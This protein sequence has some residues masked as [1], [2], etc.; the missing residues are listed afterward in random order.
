MFKNTINNKVYIGQSINI[1]KRHKE[2][3]HNHLNGNYCNYNS[4]FYRALRK[5]GFDNFE[6]SVLEECS[7]EELNTKEVEYIKQ[8]DSYRNG[9]NSTVGGEDNPSNHREIVDR[10]TE[11]LLNDPVINAKL[12]HKGEDNPNASLSEKDVITIRIRY[13]QGERKI[14]VY[15]NYKDKV[16]YSAFDY[17]WRGKT[18]SLIMPEVFETR[19]LKNT[20]GSRLCDSDVYDMKLRVKNGESKNSV[21]EDYKHLIG[22]PGFNKIMRNERWKHIVV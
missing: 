3:K 11:K 12:S 4:K 17:C 2:H 1:D 13:Q 10:R 8:Y 19:P 9:Y 14:D 20:C 5:Y 6:I 22:K 7:R 16:S 18:W 21:F 15:Q